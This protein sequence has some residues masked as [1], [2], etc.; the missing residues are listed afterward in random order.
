MQAWITLI[1]WIVISLWPVLGQTLPDTNPSTSE[2]DLAE[3][4]EFYLGH[5]AECHGRD[6]EGGRGINLTT[7]QYRLSRT[8]ADLLRLIQKGIPGTEM[9]RSRLVVADLWK[10]VAYVRSLARAGASE[11]ASGNPEAGEQ[12]YERMACATCH[13][14]GR[15]GSSLGPD[16]SDVGLRRSV[17]FLRDSLLDPSA[18]IP[19]NYPTVVVTAR[20]GKQIKGIRLNEDDFTIQARDIFENLHAYRKSEL[21]EVQAPKESLMPAYGSLL[22]EK[23]IEDL[24]A[25]LNTLRESP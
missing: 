22:S 8:D 9:P 13:V 18:Y 7:G 17:K 4:R 10:V 5:C 21:R 24:V 6:G 1:V 14:V 19:R 25:Y 20:D 3:G 15:E 11:R 12:V 23:E 16:L 2:V